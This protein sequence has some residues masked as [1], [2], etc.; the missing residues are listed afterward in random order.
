MPR[1]WLLPIVPLFVAAA[2]ATAAEKAPAPG[3]PPVPPSA[4]AADPAAPVPVLAFE[5]LNLDV[6]AV[7]EGQ[8]V[9]GTF[10]VRNTG[11]AELKLLQVKPG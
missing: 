4:P 3:T 2:F 8:D 5:A 11:Q 1:R 10:V 6:G 7:P 9:L